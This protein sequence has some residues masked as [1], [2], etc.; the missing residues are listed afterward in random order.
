MYVGWIRGN[1]RVGTDKLQRK[2]KSRYRQTTGTWTIQVICIETC[3]RSCG[4][5]MSV[6]SVTK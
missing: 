4:K 6:N 5:W 2:C 3:I 1:A